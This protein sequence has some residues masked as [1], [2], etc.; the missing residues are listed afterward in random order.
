M[1]KR[2]KM[3][4]GD[5]M[6]YALVPI[7]IILTIS[8]LVFMKLGGNPGTISFKDGGFSISMST[9]SAIG[10]IC[11]ICSFL[12]FTRIVVLFDLSFIYPLTTG[13]VQ[14]ITLVASYFV[15]KEKISVTGLVGAIL[16]MIG[17]VVMNIKTPVKDNVASNNASSDTVISQ[18]NV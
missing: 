14:T 6:K 9:V 18:E 8:G 17:I 15:F 12:L 3:K 11:Y 16:V 4:V 1:N 7:Y 13:I 2:L 5:I 10:F